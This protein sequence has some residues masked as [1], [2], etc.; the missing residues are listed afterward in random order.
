[1]AT[2]ADTW[3][4]VLTASQEFEVSTAAQAADGSTLVAGFIRGGPMG[5]LLAK[6]H[7]RTSGASI[8]SGSLGKKES[9][10]DAFVRWARAYADQTESD[11]AALVAAIKAGR[12]PA[13]HGV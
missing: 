13:E 10:V 3:L 4:R 12:L 11:H 6:G 5:H 8:I 2:D 1:M 9:A 7:A